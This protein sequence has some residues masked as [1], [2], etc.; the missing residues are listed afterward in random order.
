MPAAVSIAGTKMAL[1]ESVILAN[2]D[3][4]VKRPQYPSIVIPA[5]AGIQSFQAITD[6]RFRGNDFVFDFLQFCR[7]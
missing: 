5:K 4:F 3:G 7:L 1:P 2:I 6:S